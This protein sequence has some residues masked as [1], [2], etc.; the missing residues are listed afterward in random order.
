M[1]ALPFGEILEAAD[2]LTLEEKEALVDVL[3]HR[4]VAQRR[5]E[6]SLDV[7]EANREFD[8]GRVQVVTPDDLMKEITS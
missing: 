6:L 3:N 5:R 1:M 2:Q 4:I 8:A 7:A